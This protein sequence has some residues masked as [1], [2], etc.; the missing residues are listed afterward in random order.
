MAAHDRTTKTSSAATANAMKSLAPKPMGFRNGKKE[1]NRWKKYIPKCCRF[2]I[3]FP[4]IAA[5]APSHNGSVSEGG[6]QARAAKWCG[7]DSIAE[8][9]RFQPCRGRAPIQPAPNRYPR[10]CKPIR[11]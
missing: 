2:A 11:P 5:A 3:L 4:E 9:S 7:L 8:V 6:H 10:R 1:R